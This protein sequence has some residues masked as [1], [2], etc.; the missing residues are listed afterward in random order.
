MTHNPVMMNDGF[1]PIEQ[2]L[3]DFRDVT[4]AEDTAEWEE[5]RRIALENEAR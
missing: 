3:I 2:I 5:Y 4:E 1:H